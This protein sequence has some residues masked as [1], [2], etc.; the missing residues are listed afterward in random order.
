M[1][2]TPADIPQIKINRD[3]AEQVIYTLPKAFNHEQESL[4]YYTLPKS[5]TVML[6][7]IISRLNRQHVRLQMV[8]LDGVFFENGISEKDM[9]PSTSEVFLEK[10]YCYGFP[11]WSRHYE[12]P[13]IGKVPTLVHVRDIR[14]ALVSRYYSNRSSHPTPSSAADAGLKSEFDAGRQAAQDIDLQDLVLYL[15]EFD[16]GPRYKRLCEMAKT[17][18]VR[19]SRYEDMIYR[20][21]EWIAEVCTWLKWNIPDDK[22]DQIA[23]DVDVFPT[24]EDE[25]SHIRQVHP[26][27][28]KQKLTE[29]TI[30]RLDAM[31]AE[32]QA[33][34]G[35]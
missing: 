23:H 21:R 6:S 28:Y 16:L 2:D 10:G 24:S 19:V 8:Y 27:N 25:G 20:K 33:F 5:G 3:G 11:G 34:F 15:A 29:E 4:L 18:D 26:G 7:E 35:Y 32:E 13:L 9:P 12:N 1:T 17:Y 31:F 30:A 22:I 14:D